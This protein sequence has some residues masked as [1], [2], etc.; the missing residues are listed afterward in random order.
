MVRPP[1]ARTQHRIEALDAVLGPLGRAASLTTLAEQGA[2]AFYEGDLAA[3]LV[4]GLR[5]LGSALDLQDLATHRSEWLAPLAGPF[6]PWEVLASPPVSQGHVLLQLLSA[7][8]LLAMEQADPPGPAASCL[9]RL[10][11]LTA[12][13]RDA[14]LA[15]PR[16][17]RQDVDAWLSASTIERLAAHAK[18]LARPLPSAPPRP[19]PDGDTVRTLSTTGSTAALHVRH[20]GCAVGSSTRAVRNFDARQALRFALDVQV[21]NF[22]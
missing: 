7:L 22:E 15:D 11:A 3:T 6:G 21:R 19:R 1:S 9:A 17:V 2:R 14:T 8:R 4:Q 10:C 20:V 18:D 12:H 5:A 13:E 16:H